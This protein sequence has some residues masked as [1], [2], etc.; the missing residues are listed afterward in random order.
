MRVGGETPKARIRM[1]TGKTLSC[2]VTE[3]LAQQLGERLY[4]RIS[5]HGKATWD[6]KNHQLEEFKI[7]SIGD[8]VGGDPTEAIK[9]ISELI[10]TAYD[11]IS[12]VDKYIEELRNGD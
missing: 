9:K 8:Y 6:N 11:S 3:E 10:G 4:Q 1:I 2:D 7:D 5:L 12:D